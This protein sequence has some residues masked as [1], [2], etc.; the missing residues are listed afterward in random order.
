MTKVV[1][2][3]FT[4]SQEDADDCVELQ[5]MDRSNGKLM[6]VE[7]DLTRTRML[8]MIKDMVKKPKWQVWTKATEEEKQKDKNAKGHWEKVN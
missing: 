7:V 6:K 2:D 8:E 1:I 5:I 3:N 4:G